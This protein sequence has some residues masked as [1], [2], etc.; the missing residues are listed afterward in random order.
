[1]K[2]KIPLIKRVAYAATLVLLMAGSAEASLVFSTDFNVDYNNPDNRPFVLG[3]SGA[4]VVATQFFGA[5]QNVAVNPALAFNNTVQNRYRGVG[6]WLDTSSWATGL[7]TV[8]IEATAFTSA[9]DTSIVF[10]AFAANDVNLSNDGVSL[11]LHE[12]VSGPAL[13]RVGDGTIALLGEA[14]NIEDTGINTFTFNF[15]GTD[16]FVGLTFG[17]SNA[18]G[19]SLFG[20]ATLDN[21]TVNDSAVSVPEPSSLTLCFVGLGMTCL[22]CRRIK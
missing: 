9:A 2:N 11:D 18:S 14:Q 1:M 22:R 16:Q 20:S 5:S 3:T 19:G 6:V 17:Q 7:I 4:D 12:G 21:L 13:A 10:Q 15:N 8:D